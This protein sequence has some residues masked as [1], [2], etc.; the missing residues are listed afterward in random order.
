MYVASSSC[1]LRSAWECTAC[2]ACVASFPMYVIMA[3]T[4]VLLAGSFHPGWLATWGVISYTYP[5]TA[6]QAS[7]LAA[8]F[9]TSSSVMRGSTVAT[10]RDVARIAPLSATRASTTRRGGEESRGSPT[11][12]RR[13]HRRSHNVVARFEHFRTCRIGP[14]WQDRRKSHIGHMHFFSHR[15]KAAECT[16]RIAPTTKCIS[17]STN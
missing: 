17:C 6:I 5:S 4:V 2:H 12:T 16:T 7:S 9:A 10:P 11:A 14:S 13:Q 1:V 15:S 3:T 8:C